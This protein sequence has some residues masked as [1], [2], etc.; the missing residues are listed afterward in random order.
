MNDPYLV[1]K[2]DTVAS[3]AKRAGLTAEELRRLNHLASKD[4]IATGQTLYLSE[5]TSFGFTTL[6]LDALRHPIENLPYQLRFDDKVV[7]GKTAA[8][9]MVPRKITKNASS[10]IEVWVQNPEG[11]WQQLI[12]TTSGYGH[13]LITLVSGSVVVAGKTE[14]QPAGVP[15]QPVSPAGTVAPA[16]P[17]PTSQAAPPKPA[18][19]T[20]SKNNKAVKTK[21]AKTAQGQ[22]VL[23][24][25]VDIPKGLLDYFAKFKGGE[26]TDANWATTANALTCEEA[27]LKAISVVESG[28]NS[29]FWRL[30]KGDGAHIPAILFERHYFSKKT[31]GIYNDTFPDVSWP[32]GYR[33][34]KK[35]RANDKTMPF[36]EVEELDTYSDRVSAYLRLIEAYRLDPNAALRS[37]SWGKFQVM[38]ENF[39]ACG[40]ADLEEFVNA[41]CISEYE[42]LRMLAGFIQNKPRLWNAVKTKDWEAI[43]LNYNGPGYK[44]FNYDTKLKAA[45]EKFAPPPKDIPTGRKT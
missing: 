38:G 24:I 40:A 8:N 9:G 21:T 25:S 15:T 45:Y 5:R 43:A 41:M 3:V 36:G 19:G 39:A 42:Q 16:K 7:T 28:G 22:P 20:P 18:T 4:T 11:Q 37:C 26:I 13:K 17:N 1:T 2:G 10:A 31:K 33:T 23:Q 14:P 12:S 6:F 29:S 32:V 34:R 35:L 44:T 30:N 27:V